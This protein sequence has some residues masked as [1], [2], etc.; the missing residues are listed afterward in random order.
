MTNL[1]ALL[2]LVKPFGFLAHIEGDYI[3]LG[4]FQVTVRFFR[5]GNHPAFKQFV[6]NGCRY[7]VDKLST[8]PGFS[9][10]F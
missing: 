5:S 2:D 9:R 3:G 6:G 4:S 10:S 7:F 1:V 8:Y